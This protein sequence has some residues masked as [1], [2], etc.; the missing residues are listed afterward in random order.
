MLLN[1]LMVNGLVKLPNRR[2]L[3]FGKNGTVNRK[4][5]GLLFC[6]PNSDIAQQCIIPRIAYYNDRSNDNFD[7]V[8]AGYCTNEF[9]ELNDFEPVKVVN[10]VQWGFSGQLFNQHRF[11]LASVSSWKYSGDSDLVLGI[12]KKKT[13]GEI[14]FDFSATII[15]Q[16][17]MLLRDAAIQSVPNFFER[18]FEIA[19]SKELVSI[20][21]LSNNKLLETT[22]EMLRDKIL[23]KIGL[24]AYY[25]ANRGFAV[26]NLSK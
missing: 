18:L 24:L 26:V 14:A 10:G 16:L 19:E 22:R 7:F 5:V 25:K 4:M 9:C 11:Q 1:S 17:E 13:S 8:L 15:C 6:H 2:L 23:E 21:G 3:D 12:L 20:Y